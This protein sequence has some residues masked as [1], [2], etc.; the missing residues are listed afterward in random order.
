MGSA[1]GHGHV[2][3]LALPGGFRLVQAA[4]QPKSKIHCTAA[5]ITHQIERRHRTLVN[6]SY[7]VQCSGQRDVV[8][9]V[10]G[11]VRQR[12]RLAP[13]CHTAVDDRRIASKTGIRAQAQSFHHAWSKTFDQGIGFL[14]QPEHGFKIVWIF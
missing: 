4:H 1:I 14:D 3:D 6:V 7:G 12:T 5:K 11:G 13:A 8:D 2:N 9:I 10:P